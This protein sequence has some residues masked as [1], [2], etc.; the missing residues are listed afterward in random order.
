MAIKKNTSRIFTFVL[1]E[2]LDGSAITTGTVTPYVTLDGGTQAAA[3][4]SAVH[5][6][7]GQW[8]LTLTAAEL[9]A[10]DIGL[11]IT[12][13]TAVPVHFDIHTETE[14]AADLSVV[15]AAIVEDTGELQSDWADGGRLDLLLDEVGVQVN[16]TTENTI[17]ESE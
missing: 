9:N 3:T 17:I 5:E 11:L 1:V 16:I 13:A 7:N 15:L 4:N 2:R 12:H 14:V 10:D 8:S 6:G